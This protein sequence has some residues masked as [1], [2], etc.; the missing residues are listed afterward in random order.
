MRI[1]FGIQTA[2]TVV[3]GIAGNERI[4]NNSGHTPNP[5][6]AAIPG[7]PFRVFIF[8]NYH[9]SQR[10]DRATAVPIDVNSRTVVKIV[11]E[12]RRSFGY[13]HHPTML[14]GQIGHGD[15]DV[16]GVEDP[17]NIIPIDSG[18]IGACADNGCVG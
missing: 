18:R 14:D 5:N 12:T 13:P 6:A 7:Y 10:R 15:V 3:R 1:A 2:R 4:F 11:G 17:V 9:P 16:V 8:S